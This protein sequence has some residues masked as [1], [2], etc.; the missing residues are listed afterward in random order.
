MNTLKQVISEYVGVSPESICDDTSLVGDIGLD[1][2][3]LISL[4][5]VLEDTFEINIPDYEL[6]KFQTFQDLSNYL[7]QN[8]SVFSNM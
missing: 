6:S 7:A 5:C 2:F 4:L 3:S 8:S 1:S